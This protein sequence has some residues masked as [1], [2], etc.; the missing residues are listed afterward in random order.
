M[1]WIIILGLLALLAMFVAVKFRRHIQTGIYVLKM[2]RKM[3]QMNKPE[4]QEKQIE[5]TN[6]A[7]DV[8]LVRCT[9]CGSWIPQ[10]TALKLSKNTYY[11]SS[12]CME[13]AVRV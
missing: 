5:N 3:R 7:G 8:Q 4:K 10:N 13:T 12:K 9:K 11:C 1:K 6:T 2:F